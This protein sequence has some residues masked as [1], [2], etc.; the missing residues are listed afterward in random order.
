MNRLL[1][2][3][4][5]VR[6]GT[7]VVAVVVLLLVAVRTLDSSTRG[8]DD[9]ADTGLSAGSSLSDAGTGS[10]AYRALLRRYGFAVEV[11]R[12]RLADGGL[13]PGLDTLLV[14]DATSATDEEIMVVRRFLAAEGNVVVAGAD[15][16]LLRALGLRPPATVPAPGGAVEAPVGARRYRIDAPGL[17]VWQR[18][19]VTGPLTATPVRYEGRLVALADAAPFL[20]RNLTRADNAGFAV[21]VAGPRDGRVVFAEGVH[22][23]GGATGFDALPS[24]WR[25]ALVGG[26][27]A[28]L[29]TLVATG[30]R[31]GPPEDPDRDLG[32]GRER[33][34]TS[35]GASLERTD[36][37]E[38][39]LA[40]LQADARAA[41]ARRAGLPPDAAEPEMRRAA[42][43][44]G[45]EPDEIDALFHSVEGTDVVLA[46]GRASVR[47]RKE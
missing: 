21:A 42:A 46:V 30:R 25:Y 19:G 18:G 23:H 17:R 35:I 7:A 9:V 34:A 8:P 20:N 44:L 14:I 32:P 4:P 15:G 1:A 22:G 16:G 11:Q 5:A 26:L 29:L 40:P 13:H 2:L 24:R 39:A 36:R 28:A 10:S 37:P 45:W 41:L 33:Y 43:R 38:V 6:V 31:L 27:L 12:G 47:A 3:H